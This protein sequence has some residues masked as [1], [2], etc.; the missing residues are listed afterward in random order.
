MERERKSREEFVMKNFRGGNLVGKR[1]GNCTPSPTWKFGLVQPDGS[2]VQDFNFPPNA[3]L[4][5]RKLGASL[6]EEQPHLNL[7]MNKDGSKPNH[8]K[9]EEFKVSKQLSELSDRSPEQ[10]TSGSGLRKQVSAITTRHNPRLKRV[11]HVQQPVSPA[12]Y[13]SSMEMP[14]YRPTHSPSSSLDS[15]GK[16]GVPSYSL[17]T[18]TELLKVLNRIW[19]LEEKHELNMSLIKTL[20]RELDHS[21]VKVKE[22]LQEKKR[23]QQEI[24][25]LMKEIT[26]DKVARKYKE[27]QQMK[28]AFESIGHELEDKRKLRKHSE[29]LHYKLS[30]ELSEVKSL[31]ST[32]L[33]ELK[34]ERIARIL[35]EDL[36]DEFAKGI[37]DYEQ[38]IR[39][40]RQ[41]SHENQ[42]GREGN[43]GLILHISEAWLDER[44]QIKLADARDVAGKPSVVDKLRCEIVTFLRAK[45]S[46]NS[47]INDFISS[48]KPRESN[49]CRRSLES[50]LNKGLS[51]KQ[52]NDGAKEPASIILDSLS[53]ETAKSKP[54]KKKAVSQEVKGSD[55]SRRQIQS[56]EQVMRNHHS[57]NEEL[58][59]ENQD[60][61]TNNL[62]TNLIRNP[63]LASEGKKLRN[64]N[65]YTASSF[66]LSTFTGPSPVLKWT[67]EVKA[68][69]PNMLEPF[70]RWGRSFKPNT[71]QE[72]LLEARDHVEQKGYSSLLSFTVT[73]INSTVTKLMALGAEMDGPIKYEVH[74]KVVAMRCVDGHVLG[75]YEP[76]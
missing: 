73:D 53:I 39:L 3:T 1:E 29:N 31:F 16:F 24:A 20:K 35:L 49:S 48:E 71:L 25:E 26:E 62:P 33:N 2:L 28:D 9:I 69:D 14:S 22:L 18:S 68:A 32:A 41:K 7:K 5:A 64:G 67:S 19:K 36:C 58:A 65:D 10:A 74:G 45:Q 43:D 30:G 21:N 4:S 27:Q 70:S 75:L 15:K 8:H 12:S 66:D 47:E 57:V 40:L 46:G 61:T 56:E 6:W 72:K 23:D 59:K 17:Q 76:A 11:G 55:P 63:S 51:L 34:Q 37:R 52:G 50:Q 13:C 42:I 54:K 60:E 44:M 38:E